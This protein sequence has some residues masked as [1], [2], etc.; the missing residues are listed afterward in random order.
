MHIYGKTR[1]N[2]PLS[3]FGGGEISACPARTGNSVPPARHLAFVILTV[4][5]IRH[6]LSRLPARRALEGGLSRMT[7]YGDF[8]QNDPISGGRPSCLFRRPL[9]RLQGIVH[10]HDNRHRANSLGNGG[11]HAGD[12]FD[13]IKIHIAGEFAVG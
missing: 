6:S 11:D 1:K 13:R 5:G 9:S 2:L 12:V 7:M 4:F 10:E 3:L 8:L